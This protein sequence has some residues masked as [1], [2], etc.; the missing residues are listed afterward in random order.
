MNVRLAFN[1]WVVSVHLVQMVCVLEEEVSYM[2]RL[3]HHL[4]LYDLYQSVCRGLDGIDPLLPAEVPR[5]SGCT[6]VN[7]NLNFDFTTYDEFM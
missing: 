4:P 3:I 5:F 2:M 7:G 6:I 1:Q